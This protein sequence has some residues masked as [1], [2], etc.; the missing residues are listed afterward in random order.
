MKRSEVFGTA[1][2]ARKAVPCHFRHIEQWQYRAE[3][4]G[5]TILYRMP[6][7]RHPPRN[8]IALLCP[9]I[10]SDAR[11]FIAPHLHPVAS[12]TTACTSPSPFVS[13]LAELGQAIGQ[14]DPA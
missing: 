12:P 13:A 3:P 9:L 1:S 4:T 7:Q 11:A 8:I 5:P 10:G 14:L 2:R 6:P